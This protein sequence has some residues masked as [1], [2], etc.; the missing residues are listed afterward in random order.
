MRRPRRRR[1]RDGP[2]VLQAPTT[3]ILLRPGDVLHVREDGTFLI[4]V[5]LTPA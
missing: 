2:A 1:D 5:G 4:D 3:T